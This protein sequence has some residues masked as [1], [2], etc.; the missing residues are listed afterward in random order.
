VVVEV[1]VM[2]QIMDYLVVQV[3]VA[4]LW[5]QVVVAQQVKAQQVAQVVV[6]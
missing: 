4:L 6:Y 2:H 3:A 1:V 5:A